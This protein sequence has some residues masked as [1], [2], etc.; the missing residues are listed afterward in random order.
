MVGRAS[1][2]VKVPVEKLS[3]Q[4]FLNRAIAEPSG[5]AIEYEI[6]RPIKPVIAELVIIEGY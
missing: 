1:K 2:K 4:V 5:I 3:I 6:T